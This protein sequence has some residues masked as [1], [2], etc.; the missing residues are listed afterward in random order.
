MDSTR[1]RT[2]LGYSESVPLDEAL[3]RT[4]EWEQANPPH[5]IDPAR[6]DYAAE[7][8]AVAAYQ[9]RRNRKG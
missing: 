5:Q 2:E 9:E 6:F 8:E 1:I 4:V 7:D 3:R